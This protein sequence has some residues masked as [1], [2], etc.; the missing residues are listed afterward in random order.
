MAIAIMLYIG[1]S[2]TRKTAPAIEESSAFNSS[3]LSRPV[4]L[5]DSLSLSN[6]FLTPTKE[7]QT[8]PTDIREIIPVR[9]HSIISFNLFFKYL[10]ASSG[11]KLKFESGFIYARRFEK[12]HLYMYSGRLSS[13][14]SM[15]YPT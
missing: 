4:K 7:N 10:D 15:P 9:M 12:I 5:D 1:R 6:S 11:N 8:I 3:V 14:C 2:S 13:V